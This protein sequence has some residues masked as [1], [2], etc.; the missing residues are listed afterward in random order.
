MIDHKGF[1]IRFPQPILKQL[2]ERADAMG[3]TTSQL[4]R[5]LTIEYVTGERIL[6]RDTQPAR[7]LDDV[8][9]DWAVTE[10]GRKEAQRP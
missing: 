3:M 10:S 6:H 8:A 5:T 7:D 1:L 4:I 2:E 9:H